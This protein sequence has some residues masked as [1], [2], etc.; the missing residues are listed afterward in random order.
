MSRTTID[1]DDRLLKETMRALG[2]RTKRET[3]E[4]S[5]QEALRTQRIRALLA[6]EG[7]GYGMTLREFLR[8]RTDE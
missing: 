1:L 8:T 4:R 5:M 7:K 6:R 3:V 2:A